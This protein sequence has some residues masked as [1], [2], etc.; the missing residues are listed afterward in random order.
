MSTYLLPQDVS[1]VI[2]G[3]GRGGQFGNSGDLVM[4]ERHESIVQITE[5]AIEVGANITDHIRKTLQKFSLDAWLCN[6][7]IT[8]DELQERGFEDTVSV[9][10]PRYKLPFEATPGALFRAA[11]GA[12]DSLFSDPPKTSYDVRVLVFDTVFYRP[13]EILEQLKA[14]QEAAML[15]NIISQ[16]AVYQDMAIE[17]IALPIEEPGGANLTIE[18]KQIRTV[19]TSNVTAPAPLEKRGAPKK[20]TGSQA[21][22]TTKDAPSSA[23]LAIKA[24]QA[25]GAID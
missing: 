9:S 4:S 6:T 5:H 14:Y 1:S 13:K 20:T 10:F 11:G 17:T 24:L 3:F 21:T 22:T 7:P 16:T 23:S 2:I 18:F 12:L 25:L 19:S 15:F 8:T